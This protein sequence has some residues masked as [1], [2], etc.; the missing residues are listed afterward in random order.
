MS[1]RYRPATFFF[2][3]DDTS[4]GTVTFVVSGGLA[5]LTAATATFSTRDDDGYKVVADAS[6]TI[7]TVTTASDSTKGCTLTCNVAGT[8]CTAD[9]GRQFGQFRIVYSG[10]ATVTLPSAPVLIIHVEPAYRSL[11]AR[12]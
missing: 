1:A 12:T 10:G 9:R 2:A 4:P 6:A 8:G 7:G 3:E 5:D 11:T